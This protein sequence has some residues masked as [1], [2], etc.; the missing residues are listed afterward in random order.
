MMVNCETQDEIDHYWEKLQEGGGEV[1]CGWLVDKFGVSWQVTPV[2]LMEMQK[3]PDEQKRERV[4]Q[5]MLKMIKLDI[6]ELQRA[7]DGE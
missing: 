5:A 6:A 2:V 7:Y 1:A 3:D 4:M